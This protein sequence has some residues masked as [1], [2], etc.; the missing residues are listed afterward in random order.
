MFTEKENN[1]FYNS[2]IA[3]LLWS[4]GGS[5]DDGEFLDEGRDGSNINPHVADG[6][7][8]QCNE[9]CLQ[10]ESDLKK[11]KEEEGY[12]LDQAGHDFALSRNG[13]G[14]GFFDRKL[15]EIGARLQRAAEDFG[16]AD[17]YVGDDGS[18]Y[19]SGL[20]PKQAKIR[21]VGP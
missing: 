16:P 13:H 1:K 6:L 17:A 12:S 14:V 4:T 19:V 8:A 21:S 2:F 3:A 7:R 5:E 10:N 20:E 11:A 9:F 15:G 18:I